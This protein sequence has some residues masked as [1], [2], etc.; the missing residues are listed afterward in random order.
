[1]K[2]ILIIASITILTMGFVFVTQISYGDYIV[3]SIGSIGEA[4][5]YT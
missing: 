1:M 2:K 5:T 4:D 3:D